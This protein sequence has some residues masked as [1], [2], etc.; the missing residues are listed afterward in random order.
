MFNWWFRLGVLS[1]LRQ[2]AQ[3]CLIRH[4]NPTFN[5]ATVWLRLRGGGGAYPSRTWPPLQEQFRLLQGPWTVRG[6]IELKQVS[7]DHTAF[8]FSLDYVIC[9]WGIVQEYTKHGW[10]FFV[11]VWVGFEFLVKFESCG[12]YS[13]SQPCPPPHHD[14]CMP[15]VGG[16]R[17]SWLFFGGGGRVILIVFTYLV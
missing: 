9:S 10:Q 13:I 3:D 11:C 2:I 15:A 7:P 16:V 4:H 14:S 12:E 17:R 8:S 6:E 5:K 1:L